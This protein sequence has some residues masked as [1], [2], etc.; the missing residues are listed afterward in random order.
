MCPHLILDL[1][2]TISDPAIGIARSINYALSSFGY[3]AL[4]EKSVSHYIGPPVDETFAQITA[5]SSSEHI[6][7][8]VGKYRE[9]YAE[10]GYSENVF[11]PALSTPLSDWLGAGHPWA[12]A[13]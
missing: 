2:G 8:L 12:C 9:R 13:R 10:V 5:S 1:D 6:S 3:P 4:P 7:A 11:T